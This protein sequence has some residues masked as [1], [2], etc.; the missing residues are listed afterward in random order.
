MRIKQGVVLTGLRTEMLVGLM[1]VQEIFRKYGEEVVI[2]SVMD[3]THS[4]TSLHYAG[5][6]VD[7]RT[8]NLSNADVMEIVAE[9]KGD[10]GIHFDVVAESTHLHLEYQPRKPGA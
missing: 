3:G 5:Q 9:L 4:A 8:R 1:A 6:A 7:L 10:L 2:T